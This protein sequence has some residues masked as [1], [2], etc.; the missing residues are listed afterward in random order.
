M[1]GDQP[2]DF[3]CDLEGRLDD[4]LPNFFAEWVARCL[5][6]TTGKTLLPQDLL[7]EG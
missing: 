3:T 7:M 2:A 4:P 6:E 1:V 5:T